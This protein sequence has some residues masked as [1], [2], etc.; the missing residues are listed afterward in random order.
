[1]VQKLTL[2]TFITQVNGL[3]P[4]Q[5]TKIPQ[6]AWSGQKIYFC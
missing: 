4:G 6:D 5:E 2:S 1:M 3:I